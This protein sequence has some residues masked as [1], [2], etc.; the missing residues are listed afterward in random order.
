MPSVGDYAVLIDRA[1]RP[2][3]MAND[4]RDRGAAL[5][6]DR[7]IVGVRV[8]APASATIGLRAL[9]TTSPNRLGFAGSRCT[10]TSRLC[11][12]PWRSWPMRGGASHTIGD[13]HFGPRHRP[14]PSTGAAAEYCC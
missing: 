8:K 14:A 7:S 4:R 11:L 1:Q 5:V 2:N 13:P 10:T 3:Q 12:R 9:A 6:G